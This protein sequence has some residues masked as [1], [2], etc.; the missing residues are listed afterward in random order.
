MLGHYSEEGA[1]DTDAPSS[2]QVICVVRLGGVECFIK[3]WNW[4]DM[5]IVASSTHLC[6]FSC[7]HLWSK[8]YSGFCKAS[9]T[10]SICLTPPHRQT[11]KEKE[12]EKVLGK[13]LALFYHLYYTARNRYG[14]IFTSH[15][16]SLFSISTKKDPEIRSYQGE[17]NERESSGGGSGHHS[18]QNQPADEKL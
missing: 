1:W 10:C 5:A 14:W 7:H 8:R 13:T 2:Q 6:F 16:L 15:A 18:T 9:K 12:K 11:K 3:I 4:H 17:E